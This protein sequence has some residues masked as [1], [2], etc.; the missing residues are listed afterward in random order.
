MEALD[1]TRGTLGAD[2][3]SYVITLVVVVT[4]IIAVSYVLKYL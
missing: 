2:G 3:L 1:F 4:V